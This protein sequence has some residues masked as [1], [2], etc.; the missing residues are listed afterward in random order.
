MAV[1]NS[2]ARGFKATLVSKVLEVVVNGLLILLLTRVF[3]SNEEYGLL[4]LSISILGMA[5]FFSQM[6]LAKSA[7]R[8]VTEYRKT[9]PSL[10]PVI[11][12]RSLLCTLVAIAIVSTALVTFREVIV[13][14]FGEPALL[15]LLTLGVAFVVAQTLRYYAYFLCQGF[16]QVRWSAVLSIISNLGIFTFVVAFLTLGFGIPGAIAG[17]AMGYGLGALVGLVVLYR[18]VRQASTEALAIDD[19]DEAD[20][21][22]DG[23]DHEIHD[24]Q[25]SLTRRLLEYSLPLSITGA[26]SIMFK[27]VDIAL[28]G[29]FLTPV[30]VAYYTLAKQLTEFVAAPASS[31]G[32]ALAPTFGESKST[33]DIAQAARIYETTFEH[34]MLFYIPAA[35]GMVLVADPAIRVVFGE[36]YLG[37]IPIVQ[38][39]SIFVVLESINKLTNGAL[40]FLGRARHR[41]M[42]KGTAA[43]GNLGLNV[44]LIPTIGPVGAAISTV[45]SYAFMAAVNLYL[46]HAE[47]SLSLSRLAAT[48]AKVCTVAGGMAVAV[49]LALPY[50]TGILTLGATVALGI[51]VWLALS[52]GSGLLDLRW[53]IAQLS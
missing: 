19:A 18:W 1:R 23:T 25:K 40:D 16:N 10:V 24:E 33:D 28:V 44:L 38:V 46:I 39:L 17:Y 6:G 52:V 31:L 35:T 3:L 37:A 26:S 27:R 22:E 36:G 42:S 12:R 50:A 48:T 14:W 45:V 8:Y 15:P 47:L 5:V 4:F 34:N 41:A 7:A 21:G 29:A 43:V 30:A 49:F 2:I 53:T 51:A 20:V 11:V 32:F 13:T 9:D